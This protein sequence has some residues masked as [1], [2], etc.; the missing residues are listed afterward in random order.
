MRIVRVHARS[1]GPFQ[2]RQLELAPGMTVVHGPNESGK[3]SWHAALHAGLC[4]LRRG[5]GLRRED[6]EFV[7]RHRPWDGGDWRVTVEVALDD[8]RRIELHQDLGGSVDSRAIDAVTGEDV[9]AELLHDGAPDASRL[10]GLHRRILPATLGVRQAEVLAVLADADGLQEQLQRAAS[11]G[12]RDASVQQALRRIAAFHREHVGPDR[13]GSTRPLR[14]ALEAKRQAEEALGRAQQA[15][16]AYVE[17][18]HDRDRAAQLAG[19]AE[20]RAAAA[21]SAAVR[22]AAA[23]AVAA[24]RVE[25][26]VAG[27]ASLGVAA[28]GVVAAVA[29]VVLAVSGP[30]VAGV[31]LV[32]AGAVAIGAAVIRAWSARADDSQVDS[33]RP[34]HPNRPP[35]R[36]EPEDDLE[37]E[38]ATL[39]AE[40]RRLRIQ[41]STLDGRASDREQHLPDVAEAEEAVAAA[42]HE[43]AR[44]RNLDADLARTTRFLEAARDAVQRDA[45]PVLA[46]A[47]SDR[48]ARVTRGRYN[49]VKIDP[50]TLRVQVAGPGQSLRDATRLSR[51]TT[52]QIYL[53]LRLA[54]TEYLVTTGETAPFIID[55]ALVHADRTRATAVLDLLHE[56]STARQ[57]IVFSQE[58]EVL[59]WAAQQLVPPQDQ[60]AE[61]DRSSIGP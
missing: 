43:L 22:A 18:V 19:E 17:L 14:R 41:A 61:L 12:G 38:A 36:V 45:S 51:G 40:A 4:G 25:G 59:T 32:V 11:T 58:D 39:D 53:L 52:E 50:A 48:L 29:G 7:E 1:F 30:R 27:R 44:V 31:G 55:D 56:L 9:T 13:T 15:Q 54:L 21:R 5:P 8:G 26:P 37:A 23:R 57:I 24:E 42:E 49:D 35:G 2:D 10:L 34:P 47:V 33:R 46:A 60:L 28:A 16:Q 20:E 6:R 3:S